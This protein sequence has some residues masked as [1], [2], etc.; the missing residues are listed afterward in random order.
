MLEPGKN[1]VKDDED[2]AWEA[3]SRG[4]WLDVGGCSIR[5]QAVGSRCVR[6]GATI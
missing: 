6:H 2:V 1:E 4:R 3:G 5:K